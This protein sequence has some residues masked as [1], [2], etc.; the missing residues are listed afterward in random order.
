MKPEMERSRSNRDTTMPTLLEEM[1]AQLARSTTLT[2]H[3]GI[4]RANGADEQRRNSMTQ[5]NVSGCPTCWPELAIDA[6]EARSALK[7]EAVLMDDTHLGVWTLRCP[8]CAQLFLCVF[9]E[10][11]ESADGEDP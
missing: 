6:W 9:T 3:D 11:I 10:T 1:C 5:E 7:A 2:A 4:T 8:S